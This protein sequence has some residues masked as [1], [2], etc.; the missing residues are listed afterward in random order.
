M[1][2]NLLTRI[3]RN[4]RKLISRSVRPP[5]LC[6]SHQK[7]AA[8]ETRRRVHA[9]VSLRIVLVASG[10]LGTLLLPISGVSSPRQCGAADPGEETSPSVKIRMEEF[11]GVNDDDD[12]RN[13]IYDF[14]PLE[15]PF[16]DSNGNLM[17]DDDLAPAELSLMNPSGKSLEGYQILLYADEGMRIWNSS[18]KEYDLTHAA[19]TI[20]ERG[21]PRWQTA[22][23][24]E[25]TL[26]NRVY[27]EGFDPGT[28]IVS[29][30]L[31]DNKNCSRD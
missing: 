10:L 11:F 24:I 21:V 25:L 19:F 14:D 2:G 18:R 30:I 28:G 20:D 15:S 16:L 9:S 27:V 13:G 22:D 23:G 5:G 7:P 26:P 17:A 6:A 29:I 1:C 3:R 8:F 12:N 31:L 4:L